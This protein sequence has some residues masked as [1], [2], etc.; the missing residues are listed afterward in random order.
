MADE[1]VLRISADLQSV[2]AELQKLS[3]QVTSLNAQV[4]NIATVAK[5]AFDSMAASAAAGAASV[6]DQTKVINDALDTVIDQATSVSRAAFDL[7]GSALEKQQ[8]SADQ[9]KTA[10]LAMIQDLA[11]TAPE[12]F[13]DASELIE[14]SYERMTEAGKV[15][16]IQTKDQLE[17]QATDLEVAYK[18]MEKSGK[19]TADQLAQA[20]AKVEQAQ[21]A[22]TGEASSLFDRL[23]ETALKSLKEIGGAG[24]EAV[25]GI[26]EGVALGT[27]AANLLTEAFKKVL[28]TLVEIVK[29]TKELPFEAAKAAEEMGN[30]AIKLNAAV[31]PLSAL[32]SGMRAAGGNAEQMANVMLQLQRQLEG[33][34]AQIQHATDGLQKLGISLSQFKTLSADEQILKLS[35]GFRSLPEGA[36]K[37]AI[38]F[39][40]FGQRWRQLSVVINKDL[41]GLTDQAKKLGDTWTEEETKVGTHFDTQM[42]LMDETW[43]RIKNRFGSAILPFWTS[44]ADEILKTSGPMEQLVESTDAAAAALGMLVKTDVKI[45]FDDFVAHTGDAV[46]NLHN[47]S[48]L[49]VTINL[50]LAKL[51]GTDKDVVDATALGMRFAGVDEKTIEAFQKAAT[52]SNEL[53]ESIKNTGRVT[54][55]LRDKYG[56]TALDMV[57]SGKKVD[58]NVK[59]LAI[60]WQEYSQTLVQVNAA[61]AKTKKANDWAQFG[62][63]L[64][65]VN[66]GVA[67]LASLGLPEKLD[68]Q[69]KATENVKDAQKQLAEHYGVSEEALKKF[70]AT[71]KDDD[72]VKWAE[73]TKALSKDVEQARL[74]NEDFAL[75]LERLGPKAR[76]A[77]E[78]A[79]KL[80]AAAQQM[81]N[82]AFG[83]VAA[84]SAK[85]DPVFESW[86]KKAKA[87]ED[88][89]T[90][91][92]AAGDTEDEIATKFGAA[93]A[94]LSNAANTTVGANAAMAKSFTNLKTI[95]S[96]FEATR[97]GD[98]MH[99]WSV[100]LVADSKKAADALYAET[101]QLEALADA[102][103]KAQQRQQDASGYRTPGQ[104]A[105]DTA[106]RGAV[107]A[108]KA[109]ARAEMDLDKKLADEKA[110]NEAEADAKVFTLRKQL[111][112]EQNTSEQALIKAE[113]VMVQ[114]GQILKDRAAQE[115]HD[116]A[117][118]LN[119][120]QA[121]SDK[122]YWQHQLDL[123]NQTFDTIGQRAAD[124]GDFTK[125]QYLDQADQAAK[126]YT[127]LVE[128][129]KTA[130][131]KE[132]YSND[133][134]ERAYEAMIA[135][136]KKADG[137]W[138]GKLSQNLAS[139]SGMF[140]QLAQIGGS[141]FASIAKAI[142]TTVSSLNTGLQGLTKFKAA[143]P[144]AG[145]GM[146]F[147]SEGN[148]TGAAVAEK[149]GDPLGMVMGAIPII[150]AIAQIGQMIVQAFTTPMYK[151]LMVSV[152]QEWG[153]SI[154]EGLG[155]AIEK[156][157]QNLY[158]ASA[159]DAVDA[160]S[161]EH[162]ENFV[163]IMA[164]QQGLLLGTEAAKLLHLNE[165]I[166]EAGGLQKIT[167]AN[168]DVALKKLTLAEGK[169]H[170][171][172]SAIQEGEFDAGQAAKVLDD[173]FQTFVDAATDGTGLID[174]NLRGIIALNDQFGTQSKAIA[175]YVSKQM[176]SASAGIGNAIKVTTDAAKQGMSD[177]DTIATAQAKLDAGS[178]LGQ[179]KLQAK[180]DAAQKKIDQY[181][182]SMLTATATSRISIQAHIDALNEQITTFQDAM[183]NASTLS[184]SQQKAL[185]D[186][187]A[188]SLDDLKTQQAI[189][190]LTSVHSQ[191]SATALAAAVQGSIDAEMKAG[192][193]FIQ[194]VLDQKDAITGL[195][196]QLEAAGY[197][198]GAAFQFLKDEAELATDQISG[199]AIQAMEGWRQG[200]VG[201]SNAGRLTQDEFSGISKQILDTRQKLI[202]SGKSQSAVNAATQDDLQTIWELQ[203]QYGYAV[204]DTT[205]ALINQ[206]LQSGLI[207]EKQKSTAQQ[208][209][210]LL[211]RIADA[212][213]K[214][215][216][217][218]TKAFQTAA[219]STAQAFA[220]AA[221]AA[222]NQMGTMAKTAQQVGADMTGAFGDVYS[223]VNKVSF[224]S[225]PGGLKEFKPMLEAAKKAAADFAESSKGSMK[226]AQNAV[227]SLS[228][229]MD[230]SGSL[231]PQAAANAQQRNRA[232]AAAGQP[233]TVMINDGAIQI[234]NPQFTDPSAM[235][236][237]VR[238]IMTEFVDQLRRENIGVTQGA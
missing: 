71:L 75:T 28:E 172:F 66:A 113:I 215:A 79:K 143:M 168:A 194:A 70:L 203:V 210:D 187:I 87:L 64:D 173:N 18:E 63:E 185:Q 94:S 155:Q 82:G 104:Q 228:G 105:I 180:I 2:I 57:N 97:L 99:A 98:A 9:W 158:K 1:T 7:F 230:L 207:G 177:L 160:L 235:R 102:V 8:A 165:I 208:T 163:K 27:I 221:K 218:T 124:A 198:G 31:E 224:G 106:T 40:L 179:D 32:A 232:M 137:D 204:D 65:H 35:E 209:V 11:T 50:E 36:N 121:A 74:R 169:L 167:G 114:Q 223:A 119:E 238:R 3:G 162:P 132:K 83:N 10:Q 49:L 225:S 115:S 135:A 111:R 125:K 30:L 206:G 217:T 84:M 211:T 148:P 216:G 139:I 86:R 116:K 24:G 154:S 159:K 236:P 59:A 214:L 176:D 110:Q 88:Q 16:G 44:L 212:M 186:Q 197:D 54:A 131:D 193:T 14:K 127:Q 45:F 181:N 134:L 77:A 37:A 13:A 78:E 29:L 196:D 189:I 129:N 128:H 118:A 157:A 93:A 202:D 184:A 138:F 161:A 130:N 195:A 100:Q 126:Y 164:K 213:D 152:G 76:A 112:T 92:R 69:A 142:G 90:E 20:W 149:A 34:P 52:M 123:A 22:A 117:I 46:F 12:A 68:L 38:G 237:M 136:R 178:D 171:V 43:E 95:A 61:V 72:L 147:D 19:Y 229:S 6:V 26:A 47:L 17:K 91:A 166:S 192:K 151:K 101:K 15:F 227:D 222:N 53:A 60:R 4:E 25:A 120:D 81:L 220:D 80:G 56:Q 107:D 199:P 89:I 141:A 201:L 5:P 146:T 144:Q 231:T 153:T 21:K 55:D 174:Q 188:T 73:T 140:Q 190:D 41:T 85:F 108:A 67:K 133:T 58:D 122:S 205:Q 39:E 156:D 219:D 103:T 182:K 170:D 183:D 226:S 42:R 150:G 96:Q 109:T 48:G 175:D 23:K 33:S 200:L 51:H 233:V 62:M 191:E 145:H 234:T